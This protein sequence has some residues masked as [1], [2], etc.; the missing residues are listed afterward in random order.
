MSWKGFNTEY[1]GVYP[2]LPVPLGFVSGSL[3]AGWNLVS[4][5]MDQIMTEVSLS[6]RRPVVMEFLKC[7]RARERSREGE[8]PEFL[9]LSLEDVSGPF[10]HS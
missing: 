10:Y 8:S 9:E 7:T 6:I 3:M 2:E 1:L 5:V 4:V